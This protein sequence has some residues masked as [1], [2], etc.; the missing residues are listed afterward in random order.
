MHKFWAGIPHLLLAVLVLMSVFFSLNIMG[1]FS[2]LSSRIQRKKAPE[3]QSLIV[4]PTQM[5]SQ[6]EEVPLL[7]AFSP[8]AFIYSDGKKYLKTLDKDLMREFNENFFQF[9]LGNNLPDHLESQPMD[10]FEQYA[11]GKSYFELQY[12]DNLPVHLFGLNK[13]ALPDAWRNFSATGIA[14]VKGDQALYVLDD[15]K[16]LAYK[17][18]LKQKIDYQVV[19]NEVEANKKKFKQS[20][21]VHLKQGHDYLFDEKI[22]V[23]TFS[24]IVDRQPN[25]TFL[26]LLFDLPDQVNDYS[27]VESARYYTENKGLIVN[28]KNFEVHY[29]HTNVEKKAK[30]QL[31]EVIQAFQGLEKLWITKEDW[32]FAHYDSD[33]K[34]V[35]F[36]KNVNGIPIYGSN[37]VS[38]LKIETTKENEID[39]KFSV[40]AIQT[41]ITDLTEHFELQPASKILHLLEANG[42]SSEDIDSLKLGYYWVP[43][44]KSNRL[45]SLLPC[46]MIEK[47]GHYYVL[48]ELVD[49]HKHEDCVTRDENTKAPIY[50]EFKKQGDTVQ[51]AEIDAKEEERYF[52]NSRKVKR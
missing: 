45:V 49:M 4:T 29:T 23:P 40:L 20:K 48:D 3:G 14:Y 16:N 15:C 52:P 50:I 17:L 27:D 24:Y 43:S 25:D 37:Y 6:G 8:E 35:I 26:Q 28:N 44:P 21:L 13:E 41:P 34:Q 31:E 5:I 33:T 10:Q 38:R 39:S 30:D 42:I 47:E 46:W 2:N 51:P 12:S 22:S 36:R 7:K 32:S 11:L 19:E 9:S 1:P 18:P